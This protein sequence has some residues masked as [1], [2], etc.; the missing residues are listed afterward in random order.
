RG[1]PAGRLRTCRCSRRGRRASVS[2][3]RSSYRAAADAFGFA[4]QDEGLDLWTRQLDGGLLVGR[5][6]RQTSQAK[7]A[8]RDGRLDRRPS[9]DVIALMQ[10][11]ILDV[12]GTGLPDAVKILDG[13][14]RRVPA[15]YF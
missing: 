10:L 4:R 8:H 12:A 3:A 7:D 2:P 11:R 13:P 15:E 9:L 14:A 6:P 5:H 1:R